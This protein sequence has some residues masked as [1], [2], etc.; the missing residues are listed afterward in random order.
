MKQFN[1]ADK[2]TVD[3]PLFIRLLEYARED[4]KT[5]MDLHNVAEKAVAASETGKTLTMT[6]YDALVADNSEDQEM[7]ETK[8]MQQL[9]GLIK[10]DTASDINKLFDKDLWSGAAQQGKILK[11][12]QYL[13]QGRDTEALSFSG[14]NVKLVDALKEYLAQI[15]K[16]KIE[17]LKAKGGEEI[18]KI[19][20]KSIEPL[21][22]YLGKSGALK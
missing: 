4:A 8:R 17:A 19:F 20:Q 21:I 11:V 1:P 9:A 14:N 22:D 6:D 7:N 5:D 2:I 10:E 18:Q 3:V 13:I 15:P 12:I 16:D